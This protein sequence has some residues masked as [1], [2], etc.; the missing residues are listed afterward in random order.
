[1]PV[2]LRSELARLINVYQLITMFILMKINYGSETL[3]IYIVKYIFGMEKGSLHNMEISFRIVTKA[4][5][6]DY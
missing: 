1:M 2:L 3:Y 6:S 5:L 4:F